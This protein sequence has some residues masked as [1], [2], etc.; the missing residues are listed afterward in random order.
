MTELEIVEFY[1]MFAALVSTLWV[2]TPFW[3]EKWKCCWPLPSTFG[4]FKMD[5]ANFLL[6][7]LFGLG[8]SCNW[9]LVMPLAQVGN[10]DFREPL[11]EVSVTALSLP[12]T[13]RA[14]LIRCFLGLPRRKR[15]SRGARR[16]QIWLS[17][18]CQ[19][20]PSRKKRK[21]SVDQ[22]RWESKG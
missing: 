14:L 2:I 15:W 19:K 10:L 8:F 16:G 17:R 20:N 9:S 4:L 12:H 21:G 11:I 6:P 22:E 7:L 18:K 13:R 5:L 3:G 1:N